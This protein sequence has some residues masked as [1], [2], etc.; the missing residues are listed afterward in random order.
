[1]IT[2]VLLLLAE[3]EGKKKYLSIYKAIQHTFYSY[4]DCSSILLK[5]NLIEHINIIVNFDLKE[6][7]ITP[8]EVATLKEDLKILKRVVKFMEKRGIEALYYS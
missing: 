6:K 5:H 2:Y 4:G 3:L 8:N 1:M 7:E